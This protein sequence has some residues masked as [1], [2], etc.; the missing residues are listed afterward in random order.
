[1]ILT[2][3][4]TFLESLSSEQK[5]WWEDSENASERTEIENYIK[6][7]GCAEESKEFAEKMINAIII[8]F[9]N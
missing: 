2:I 7:N 5:A 8:N 9:I 1:C 3:A 6:D 4:V